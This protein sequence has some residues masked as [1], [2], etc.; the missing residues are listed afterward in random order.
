MRASDA[1]GRTA[2]KRSDRRCIV[3]LGVLGKRKKEGGT[4]NAR[5]RNVKR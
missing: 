1:T 5:K 3:V 4:Q 2:T